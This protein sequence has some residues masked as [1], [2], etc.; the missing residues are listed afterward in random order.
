MPTVLAS[1]PQHQATHLSALCH[2]HHQAFLGG[3]PGTRTPPLPQP[4]L[5]RS[6]LFPLPHTLATLLTAPKTQCQTCFGV[7]TPFSSSHDSSR[8]L[9]PSRCHP[10]LRLQ[11]DCT[12]SMKSLKLTMETTEQTD[13]HRNRER[14]R[15]RDRGTE[16]ETQRQRE[17]EKQ[18]LE[19]R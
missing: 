9:C 19:R 11:A 2:P 4:A 17:T 12:F 6:S 3:H 18:G 7:S 5:H 1:S 8:A 13:R 14:W 10:I 15:H 16:T